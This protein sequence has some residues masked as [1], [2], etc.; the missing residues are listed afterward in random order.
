MS[1]DYCCT[2]SHTPPW[3]QCHRK[4]VYFFSCFWELGSSFLQF[5]SPHSDT[6]FG[7][8]STHLVGANR[9]Q[10]DLD[11]SSLYMILF[12]GR[13]PRGRKQKLQLLLR[14]SIRS[15]ILSSQPHF[16]C[17]SKS[18]DQREETSSVGGSVNHIAM[19]RYPQAGICGKF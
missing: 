17:Q 15:H 13:I 3:N 16:A 12:Q 4:V 11:L 2:I 18:P 5:S 10:G 9:W 7:T 19:D 6:A 14:P 1:V 8:W